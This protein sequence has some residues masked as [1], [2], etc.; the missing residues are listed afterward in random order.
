MKKYVVKLTEGERERLRKLVSADMA[1][2]RMLNRARVLLK[3]GVGEHADDS[4]A[5]TDREI[6]RMLETSEATVG[7]GAQALLPTRARCRARTLGARS[8]VRALFGWVCRG[9]PD[10]AGVL[11]SAVRPRPVEHTPPGR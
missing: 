5:F 4:P 11:E 8:G 1:S 9:S 10:R 3:S 6:A 2:A 7:A